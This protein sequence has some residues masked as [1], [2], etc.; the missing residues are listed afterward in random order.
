[1]Y[2]FWGEQKNVTRFRDFFYLSVQLCSRFIAGVAND[3]CI[4]ICLKQHFDA[5]I[6]K[7][8]DLT[9][10]GRSP[11]LLNNFNQNN[12]YKF[13]LT[14]HKESSYKIWVQLA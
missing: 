5:D 1:M 11:D 12:L 6:L 8:E 3:W 2:K 10:L 7:V 14:Y 13:W 9:V 4:I